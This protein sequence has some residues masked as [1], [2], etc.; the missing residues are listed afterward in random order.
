VFTNPA[1]LDGDAN[2]LKAVKYVSVA[3]AGEKAI[4]FTYLI[5]K[6]LK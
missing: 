6:V 5:L 3:E 1:K 4:A 2:T